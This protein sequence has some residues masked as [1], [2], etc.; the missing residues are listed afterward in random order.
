[1]TFG[2]AIKT[3]F[4][5]YAVFQ[6]RAG[7]AEFWWWYLF[8]A[9]ISFVISMTMNISTAG[10]GTDLNAILAASAPFFVISGIVGLALLLPTLGVTVR[11]LHDTNRSGGWWFISLVP[12]V[13]AII[14]IVFMFLPSVD[15]GNRFN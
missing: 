1:M 12:F 13:G 6:G 3:V 14:L 5:K 9:L 11:R 7:R 15:E 4:N 8:T 2:Q 10:A